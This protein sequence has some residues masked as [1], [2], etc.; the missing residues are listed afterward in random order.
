MKAE[1]LRC[2]NFLGTDAF[3][4]VSPGKRLRLVCGLTSSRRA[5]RLQSRD[6]KPRADT[7]LTVAAAWL[8]K[9]RG[10][11]SGQCR[12]AGSPRRLRDVDE[13]GPSSDEASPWTKACR[14]HC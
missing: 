1:L 5:N 10:V 8:P 14:C 13:A 2:G 12:A 9:G 3:E 11:Q 4:S 6:A 7:V